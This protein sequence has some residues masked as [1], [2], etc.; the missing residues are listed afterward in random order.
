MQQNMTLNEQ[1][2]RHIQSP[3]DRISGAP[4]MLQGAP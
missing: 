1:H 4:R 3:F 2:V